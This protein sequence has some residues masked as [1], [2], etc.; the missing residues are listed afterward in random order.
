MGQVLVRN[1]DDELKERLKESARR[2]G[3]SLESEIRERLRASIGPS[4]TW[5]TKPTSDGTDPATRTTVREVAE[6][7]RGV[8]FDAEEVSAIAALRRAPLVLDHLDA[9]VRSYWEQRAR[10]NGRTL[11]DEVHAL[12]TEKARWLGATGR[13]FGSAVVRLFRDDPFGRGEIQELPLRGWQYP[14]VGD[15]E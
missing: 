5:S 1:V 9:D 8:G 7:F 3:R 15:E 6:Q 4:D 13:G 11:S 12:L 10:A 14:D 2:N